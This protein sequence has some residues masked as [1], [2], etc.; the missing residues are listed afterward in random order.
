MTSA[1]EHV[2]R[3]RE[4]GGTYEAIATAASVGAM[5]VHAI[6]NRDVQ[7]TP[8]TAAALLAVTPERLPQRRLEA[9]GTAWQLRSLMAMGHTG[10]G[11]L[12]RAMDVHPQTVMRLVRGEATT[13]SARLRQAAADIWEPWWDKVPPIRTAEESAA[14][15]APGPGRGRPTGRRR[16]AWTR[17]AWTSRATG[18]HSTGT[19]PRAR[20]SHP[21]RPDVPRGPAQRRQ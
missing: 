1:S 14:A 7:V 15:G 3:L 18:R 4:A 19:P 6:A 17:S 8:A 12:A 16:W 5:T 13:V 11:R 9:G 21:T 2:N 20:V 10:T